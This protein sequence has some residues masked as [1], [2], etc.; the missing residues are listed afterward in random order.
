[1]LSYSK[2][3]FRLPALIE[4]IDDRRV[5]PRIPTRTVVRSILAMFLARLGS[6]NALEQTQP[7][8]FWRQWIGSDLPSADSIGRIAGKM[9]PDSIR[10]VL[11]SVYTQLK[12][13]KALPPTSGGLMV[14]LLD[15]HESHATYRRQCT[16]CLQ[17]TVQTKRGDCIQYYHRQVTAMLI[18]AGFPLL[19]DAESV[20]ASE[21]EIAAA[22]RLLERLLLEY[23]RAFDVVA[24]DA[25]Y[26]DPRIYN[27]ALDHGKDLLTVL[28]ANQPDLLL[29]ATALCAESAPVTVPGRAVLTQAWD[30]SGFTT[31]PQV[32]HP[33]RVV[34]S[35]E[36]TRVRRQLDRAFEQSVSDWMWVTTLSPHRAST[37]RVIRLGHARW[38]IENRGFNDTVNRWHADHV[39]KHAADAMQVFWLLTMLAFNLFYAFCFRNLKNSMLQRYSFQHVARWIASGIYQGLPLGSPR[40]P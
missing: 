3:I 10:H 40:P 39:Y 9:D 1:M 6:L 30:L 35:R 32:S 12:R 4:T 28:K 23:P 34:K 37:A 19:L 16:G 25:L 33:V 7:S 17:R 29:D 5:K 20:R 38:D 15:G 26:S 36:T 31:W 22:L 21:D 14:L 11:H 18:G 24:G 27:V 2:K 8:S 13:N